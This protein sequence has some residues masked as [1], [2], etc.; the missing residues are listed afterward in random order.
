MK[1]ILYLVC[2]NFINLV[3]YH[4]VHTGIF[5]E[6]SKKLLGKRIFNYGWNLLMN[7]KTE[8]VELQLDQI[9]VLFFNYMDLLI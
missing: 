6:L 5:G 2:G 9:Q 1:N 7:I 8:V 3:G 4:M